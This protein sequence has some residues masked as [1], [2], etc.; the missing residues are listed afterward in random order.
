MNAPTALRVYAELLDA[1]ERLGPIPETFEA[2]DARLDE[3]DT[4]PDSYCIECARPSRACTC[5]ETA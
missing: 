3:L 5:K 4:D 2:A 1:L